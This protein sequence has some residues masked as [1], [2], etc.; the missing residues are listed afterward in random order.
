MIG[1]GYTT[2]NRNSVIR[3]AINNIKRYTK[4][5][6]KLVIVDDASK[7]PVIGATYRFDVN[8]GI[9][10]AKNKCLELLDD[11]DHIFLF[12][13]DCYPKKIDWHKPYTQSGLNHLSFTFDRLADG[14]LNGNEKID[15]IDNFNI[16]NNPCGCMLYINRKCLDVVGGFDTAYKRYG[17]EHG[18]FSRRV[19]N[20]GLTPHLFMDIKNSLEL[21]HSMDY[22]KRINTTVKNKM[23]FREANKKLYIKNKD[24]KEY[25]PYKEK[26]TPKVKH[27]NV[28][29][30]SYFNYSEDP[31]RGVKWKSDIDNVRV[32]LESCIKHKQKIILFHDCFKG[33]E[34]K[35]K[36]VKFEKT[37]PSNTH[38]PNVYRCIVYYEWMKHNTFDK[39][40]FVDSTD[41]E[42][43]KDPFKIIENDKLY[44]GDECDMKTDNNWMR[45]HQERHLRSITDY[46]HIIQRNANTRLLNC[47][48][49]GGHYNIIKQ[50]IGIQATI[51]KDHT[52]GLRFSTDMAVFNYVARKYFND[53]IVHGEEINTKF[54]HYEKENKTAIWKHK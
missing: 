17:F 14:R 7:V 48:I 41:V 27:G 36:Y 12:D 47:G 40:W 10:V 51:H 28:I 38:S 26:E 53:N 11:C 30:T 2:H 31:Q 15:E 45:T 3:E 4:V 23:E 8:V 16:F 34:I 29:L 33:D 18:D 13:D 19:Y 32:L 35:S 46:R 43:L 22:H 44:S 5:P 49:Y 6:Y 54:K 24:S 42:L 52:C 25:M 50:F 37:T 9:S 21:F 39:I 1:I 20:N